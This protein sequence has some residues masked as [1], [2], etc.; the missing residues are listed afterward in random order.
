LTRTNEGINQNTL[1]QFIDGLDV[2]ESV[3]EELRAI[4]PHTYTG[5]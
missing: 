2:P 3:K 4:T 5:F 1:L